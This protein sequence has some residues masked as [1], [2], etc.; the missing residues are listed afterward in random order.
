MPEKPTHRVV[1]R[2]VQAE[3]TAPARTALRDLLFAQGVEF[4]CG[5]Q[6]R[7][8]CCRVHVLEDEGSVNDAQ[9]ERLSALEDF[10]GSP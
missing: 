10:I 4:P 2:P 7:C 3:L 9:R 1:L 5:G 8:R 6:D